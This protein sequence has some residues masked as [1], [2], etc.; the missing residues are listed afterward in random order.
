MQKFRL[1][2]HFHTIHTRK[3]KKEHKSTCVSAQ[4]II[5]FRFCWCVPTTTMK[6]GKKLM[7]KVN[8][9]EK[10]VT[11]LF[12]VFFFVFRHSE[13]F[14]IYKNVYYLFIY[15]FIFRLNFL[16]HV[17]RPYYFINAFCINN[18]LLTKIL[19]QGRRVFEGSFYFN[20]INLANDKQVNI[21]RV[22]LLLFKIQFIFL[23][24]SI[25]E[26]TFIFLRAKHMERKKCEIRS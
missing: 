17:V 16:F 2:L 26:S 6:N 4:W 18:Y 10:R 24:F 22:P 14:N 15:L 13:K 1:P 20:V 11:F 25:I 3:K 21:F 7:W 5:F 23:I 8:K 12:M 19:W 9:C